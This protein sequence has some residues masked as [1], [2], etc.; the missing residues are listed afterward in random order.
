MNKPL[1]LALLAAALTAPAEQISQELLLRLTT[2]ISSRSKAGTRFSAVV[3]G[4]ASAACDAVLPPGSTMHGFLR[5]VLPVGFG[6]RRERA[7]VALEF[8]NCLSPDGTSL[9]CRAALQGI[10]N[11]RETV[12]RGNRIHGILAAN[13]PHSLLGGV[14]LRPSSAMVPRAA[15]G[16][17]GAGRMLYTGISPHPIFAGAVI[18]TRLAVTRL[19]DPEIYLPAGTELIVRVK[20]AAP[21]NTPDPAPIED[22]PRWPATAPV[23]I[24]LP[25]GATAT[26]IINFAFRGTRE[27]VEAAFRGAGWAPAD[28]LNAHTFARTYHAVS[29]MSAYPTA[30]VS[31]LRYQGRLPG[32]V[33]QKS[34]NSMA[35]RHHIRLWQVDSPD[36]PIWLGA[37]THDIAIAFDWKRLSLTHRIDHAIDGERDKL[38]AD[39]RFAA[40]IARSD[41]LDR[42][43]LAENSTRLTTDGALYV[44][45]PQTCA[46]PPSATLES[47]ARPHTALGKAF[48]RRT[49][50]ESRHYLTRNN[51]YFWAYRGL[52][53]RQM[54][55]H[56]RPKKEFVADSDAPSDW[57]RGS[58]SNRRMRV[59]QTLALPLG[60]RA[61][62]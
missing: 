12:T 21:E 61:A 23:N 59:L 38:L 9:P 14:W 33:F 51:G 6:V 4:C 22:T 46:N 37:A 54:L 39:L 7:T 42:P 18:A 53:S 17:T 11:A 43:A 10:D 28:P 27:Q 60:Y 56:F 52:R 29:A 48:L 62:R 1:A 34:F 25:D 8:D 36:G 13:H 35:K 45:T 16:I 44:I 2:P 47:A 55:G 26:D 15:A 5:E 57:R 24:T 40:C 31:P 49:I 41:R 50:L 58:E 3:T 19:P 20:A 32:L 30:P